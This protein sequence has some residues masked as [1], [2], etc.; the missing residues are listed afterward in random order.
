MLHTQSLRR[1]G[2]CALYCLVLGVLTA[3]VSAQ[4]RVRARV[5]PNPEGVTDKLVFDTN[6]DST[7]NIAPNI[8]FTAD[9]SRG[10]VAYPGSG[11]VAVF[12]V[13]NGAVLNRIDT[14][15]KPYWGLLL[16][17][18]HTVAYTST[19]GN[20]LFLVDENSALQTGVWAFSGAQFGFGSIPV[21]SPDGNYGYISSTGT[22]EVIKFRI[23][24]GKEEGRLAGLQAPAQLAISNDGGTLIVVDAIKEELVFVDT[25][26]LNRRATITPP[27]DRAINFT[28]FNRPVLAPDGVTGI[29]ASRDVNGT[30][31]S[32]SVY[33]FKT[34]TGELLDTGSIGSEPGFTGLTPDG[35]YW[36]VYCEFSI[37]LISTADFKTRRELQLSHGEPIG[38]ANIVFTPD[39]KFAYYASSAD[40]LVYEHQIDDD[41][42]LGQM[43]IGDNPNTYL[44]QPSAMAITPDGKTIAVLEFT[45]NDID[46]LASA[47]TLNSA[48]FINSADLFTG[49]TLINLSNTTNKFTVY[50]LD[51]YGQP[52]AGTGVTNPATYVLEPNAQVSKTVAQMFTLDST[53]ET[54]GWISVYSEQPQVTGYSSIGDNS[55]NRLD[56]VPLF[57]ATSS[58]DWVIPEV[59][60]HEGTLL[61]FNYVNPGFS[62]A[63]YNAVYQGADGTV[64]NTST[65][66]VAYPTNRQTQYF[67]DLFTDPAEVSNGYMRITSNKGL[68]FSE[69]LTTANTMSELNGIDVNR[70]NGISTVYSPQFAVTPAYNTILNVINASPD[71]AD[72]T[73]TLHAAD[74]S[75]VGQPYHKRLVKGQQLKQ[76]LAALFQGDPAVAD[77]T[78]WLEVTSTKDR[79]LGT[80]SFTNDQNSFATTFELLGS[81]QA[82]FLFPVLAQDDVY[83]T[84]IALLNANAEPAHLTL[85]VRGEG[86]TLDG[87]AEITLAA[88]HRTALYLPSFFPNLGPRLTGHVRVRA[89]K[90][91]FGFSLIHDARFTFMTAI[92]ALP[93]P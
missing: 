14:G 75:A 66:N 31:G 3:E 37:S 62:Q 40:D 89:D 83:R 29:V 32:D 21:L 18:G 30:L 7:D 67:G 71:D 50:A 38:S 87:S 65:G 80:I 24:D 84:G 92:P 1:F 5:E 61:E 13:A 76:N 16:P 41:A 90:P 48:K 10:F 44:D 58:T 82:N 28:I 23:A 19:L 53:K 27:S 56:A 43:L 26:S 60:R 79:V 15:G 73:I 68:I 63:L 47:V 39:S 4:T 36:A 69:F 72:I 34:A 70:Y 77:I 93:L 52:L 49:L 78:G 25:S 20:E 6:L 45:S 64:L 22:G 42:I 51:N 9:S 81:P 12:S 35:R 33:L 91:L 2:N 74:G 59:A 85:E 11:V 8:L 17:D 57:V 86:G 54:T 55:L 46:L 88:G